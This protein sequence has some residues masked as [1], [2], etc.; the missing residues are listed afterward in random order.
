LISN[1]TKNTVNLVSHPYSVWRDNKSSSNSFGNSVSL[2]P[3][4]RMHS[5]TAC[6]SCSLH[7]A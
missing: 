4:W 3:C 2:L 5:P 7:N 6:A 1:Q